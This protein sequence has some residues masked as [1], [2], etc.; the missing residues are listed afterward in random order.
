MDTETDRRLDRLG[1][2]QP[3]AL[4][5]REAV[6]NARIAYEHYERMLA[7]ERWKR[8]APDRSGCCGRPRA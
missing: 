2:G 7:T 8:L 6:T 5:G 1:G 4:R 3:A